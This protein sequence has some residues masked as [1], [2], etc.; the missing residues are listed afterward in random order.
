MSFLSLVLRRAPEPEISERA[1]SERA[2]TQ[3][4]SLEDVLMELSKWGSPRL[5]MYGSDGTWCCSIEVNVTATG[6]KFE[7]R[8]DFK[9]L[10]PLAAAL[11]CRQN[12][13]DAVKAI[14]GA[15]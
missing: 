10:T 14:G 5:G 9:Q 13:R 12:L 8:S 11:M 6:V 3:A 1:T 7:A 2:A 15:A 4:E